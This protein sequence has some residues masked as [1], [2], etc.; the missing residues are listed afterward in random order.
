VVYKNILQEKE[1]KTITRQ[2]KGINNGG[3]VKEK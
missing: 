2:E 3:E 1:Q